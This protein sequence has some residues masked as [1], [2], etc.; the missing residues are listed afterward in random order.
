MPPSTSARAV[1]DPAVPTRFQ[2]TAL[3]TRAAALL[4]I[5][6]GAFAA[7]A[8]LATEP[9]D[10]QVDRLIETMDMQRMLGNLLAQMDAM[11][12]EMGERF[13]GEGITPEQRERIRQTI[14]RQ[15]AGTR[16][17]MSW[18]KIGPIYR[19]VYRKLFTAEEIDAMIAFYGSPAGRS[20]LQKMPKAMELAMEDMQPIMETLIA[21]LQKELEK[22]ALDSDEGSTV[23][24]I[25]PPPR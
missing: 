9:S 22:Q 16:N 11:N 24:I 10:A 1:A 25:E 7:P 20:I 23:Q 5:V 15:Q 21:D 12:L 8:A 4:L 17:A 3:R 18:E 2:M 13:M 6:A 14:A 19:N